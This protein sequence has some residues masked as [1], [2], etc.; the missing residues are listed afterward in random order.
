VNRRTVAIVIT[1]VLIF[2]GINWSR[3]ARDV[4]EPALLRESSVVWVQLGKG[5]SP[6]GLVCQFYDDCRLESVIELTSYGFAADN[7]NILSIN[8]PIESGRRIDLIVQDAEIQSISFSWMTAGK[9]VALGIPLHPDRMTVEDWE[10]LPGIGAKTAAKIE[11]NRQKNGDF[12]AFAGLR[13]IKGVGSSKM[14]T[15]RQFFLK[16][17]EFVND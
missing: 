1:V 5:F 7:Q 11:E 8:P 2:V 10:F 17:S 15:W 9:R 6:S 14:A 12:G 4:G 16:N 13:R 3:F